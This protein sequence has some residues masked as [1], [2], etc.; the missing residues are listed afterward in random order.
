L[1]IDKTS[2][3]Y[4][5]DVA[6]YDMVYG[7]LE[8]LRIYILMLTRK[9]R[10]DVVEKVE[11]FEN[12]QEFEA[13]IENNDNGIKY[14]CNYEPINSDEY[15][16]RYVFQKRDEEFIS[17]FLQENSFEELEARF[18]KEEVVECVKEDDIPF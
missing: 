8:I 17:L 4:I 6:V 3:N 9:N 16:Y 10:D 5:Y 18:V 7:K 14:L 11:S 13:Y 1:T 12:V 2:L 15:I